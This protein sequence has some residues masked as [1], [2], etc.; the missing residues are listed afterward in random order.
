MRKKI[1]L[2]E[3]FE[4]PVTAEKLQK[5]V[6][7]V[8]AIIASA[9]DGD[10]DPLEVFDP[11]NTWEAPL[12]FKPFILKNGFLFSE[13]EEYTGHKPVIHKERYKPSDSGDAFKWMNQ[14][15]VWYRKA[16]RKAGK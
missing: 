8:N 5:K 16:L 9:K 12:K 7:E 3:G 2:F 6:D 15:A 10:G 13:Y 14:V 11:T 1:K 4:V